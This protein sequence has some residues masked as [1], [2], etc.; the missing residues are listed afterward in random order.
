M[1]I[2]QSLLTPHGTENNMKEGPM[3]KVGKPHVA[4]SVRGQENYSHTKNVV[5]DAKI[6]WIK[7]NKMG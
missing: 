6:L 1:T 3:E 4:K 5:L 7:T 2:A